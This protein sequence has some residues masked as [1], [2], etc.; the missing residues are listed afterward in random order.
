LIGPEAVEQVED[1]VLIS[2]TTVF[3][4]DVAEEVLAPMVQ[5]LLQQERTGFAVGSFLVSLFLASR[6]FRS[7]IDTLDA[8]Y[9]VEERR[10]IVALW[11]LGFLFALGAI[12]TVSA[13][14]AMVVVGPFLGGGH[15]LAGWLGL[16]RVFE[17]AWTFAR[18]PVLFAIA[19]GFL[20]SLYRFGPNVRNDWRQSLPGAALG[21]VALIAVSIGFRLYLDVTG[22][23]SPEIR[24]ADAAVVV[25][26]Q[27]IGVILAALLWLWLSAMVVLSGGVLNAELSR[28]RHEEPELRA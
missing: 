1:A 24:D 15:A 23:E 11:G 28:L 3:S 25:G 16:G 21:V 10:G 26:A 2:L 14:L 5:G 22:L 13:M 20:A 18:W 27:V 4:A 17:I 9:R 12:L 19:A 7:A 6:V 8:A